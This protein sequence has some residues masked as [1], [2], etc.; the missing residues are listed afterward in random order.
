MPTA[1]TMLAANG[2]PFALP[3]KRLETVFA[4]TDTIGAEAIAAGPIA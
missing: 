1:A 3:I 2:R 4:G